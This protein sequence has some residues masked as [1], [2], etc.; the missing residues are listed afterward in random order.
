MNLSSCQSSNWMAISPNCTSWPLLFP[1]STIT[2]VR[3]SWH[4]MK[5]SLSSDKILKRYLAFFQSLPSSS[6]LFPQLLPFILV[7]NKV[8][9]IWNLK[10]LFTYG[11]TYPW[12]IILGMGSCGWALVSILLWFFMTFFAFFIALWIV[13]VLMMSFKRSCMRFFFLDFLTFEWLC[14]A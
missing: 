11:K 2:T 1:K 10:L 12:F 7:K 6:L 4:S 5:Y 9:P 13:I 3:E 8:A 14:L